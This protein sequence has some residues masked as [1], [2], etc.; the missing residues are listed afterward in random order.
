MKRIVLLFIINFIISCQSSINFEEEK[1]KIQSQ[2]DLVE[3][4][5]FN[6]DAFKF[7]QPNAENWY[8]IREGLILKV[9][10]NDQ[11]TS[12]QTYLDNMEFQQLIKRD[13]PIIE[14]SNDGSMASY[15]GSVTIKGIFKKEPVFWVVAWQNVLKKINGEWKIISSVNT[16]ANK[17]TSA[18]VVLDQVRESL[19]IS[20]EIENFSIYALADCFGHKKSFKTLILS[21]ETDGR[22]EQI[23]DDHHV[24]MKH[25]KD[26]SWIYNMNSKSQS[27]TM[28]ESTKMFVQ[29]HELHWLSFWP[30]H[31]FVNPLLKEIKKFKDQLAFKIQFN[32]TQ[33]RIVNIYYA[34]DTYLPLGIEITINNEGEIVTVYFENWE[35]INDISVFKKA[36]FEQG[37]ERFEYNYVD[38]KIADLDTQAFE[39]KNTSIE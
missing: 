36:I 28:D 30:E 25:G 11:I 16:Q 2:I 20:T 31:R 35:K 14:I 37:T 4:A 26:S 3:Q 32:N 27:E 21:S 5:H 8:D 17:Q 10:K 22:M 29:G 1:I 13:E 7:Y 38:I 12:T 23:Y 34:F 33:N 39:S 9:N 18:N 15:I 6:K 19:G 24:I